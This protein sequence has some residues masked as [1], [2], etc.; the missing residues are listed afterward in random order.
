MFLSY[1][2]W[3]LVELVLGGREVGLWVW[4]AK[5]VDFPYYIFKAV[6]IWVIALRQVQ[7]NYVKAN[8]NPSRLSAWFHE[9]NQGWQAFLSLCSVLLIE[10]LLFPCFSGA[11]LQPTSECMMTKAAH[12]VPVIIWHAG[13]LLCSQAFRENQAL[14]R[15]TCRK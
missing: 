3:H 7:A 10:L 2:L 12:W 14:W 8:I 9:R 13:L 15:Q 1:F 11:E 4:G 5:L 6:V